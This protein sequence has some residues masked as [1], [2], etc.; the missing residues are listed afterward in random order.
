MNEL[1]KDHGYEAIVMLME[2]LRPK[3]PMDMN[4]PILDEANMKLTALPITYQSIWKIYKEQMSSF[5][6]EEEIDLSN[7]Y[8]D[9][10][11]LNSDE[12]YF[13]EMILA[14]FAA[15][16][17]IVNMNLSERFISEVKITEIIYAYQWQ[18]MMENIHSTMYSLMLENIVK[19][20]IRRQFLF[21]AFRTVPSVKAMADW[22]LQWI[23]SNMSFAHRVVAFAIVEGI[24]F[25]GAFAAIYWIKEYKN[26]NRDMAKGRPFMDGLNKSNKLDCKK[27]FTS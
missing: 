20:P 5:W 7:D 14:F 24:F 10:L 8:D 17:G 1:I 11:T 23:D 26:T 16:D 19:D 18:A 13:I 3:N 2:K 6:K 27:C 21:D 22:A 25:S 15:Q 9:F 4:E 12:Q